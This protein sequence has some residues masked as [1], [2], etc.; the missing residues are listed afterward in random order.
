[1]LTTPTRSIAF[2]TYFFNTGRL[3]NYNSFDKA[4]SYIKTAITRK[5]RL[6]QQISKRL[7]LEEE[8]ATQP[9]IIG[10]DAREET[11][12]SLQKRSL[13]GEIIIIS[14]DYNQG[15][16]NAM[17]YASGGMAP[18]QISRNANESKRATRDSNRSRDATKE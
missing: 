1:M 13:A 8:P 2:E 17:K 11:R 6:L 18:S 3:F 10:K 14:P 4:C 15:Q 7:D 5:H 9:V 12:H 16:R